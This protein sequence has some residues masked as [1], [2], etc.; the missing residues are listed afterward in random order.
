MWRCK[1]YLAVWIT[2]DLFPWS[3]GN[4]EKAK[5]VPQRRFHP[6]KA[7]GNIYTTSQAGLGTLFLIQQQPSVNHHCRDYIRVAPPGERH[8]NRLYRLCHSIFLVHEHA[9]EGCCGGAQRPTTSP[10]LWLHQTLIKEFMEDLTVLGGRWLLQEPEKLTTWARVSFKQNQDPSGSRK[11]RSPAS[12]AFLSV[13][14]L[15]LHQ[16]WGAC[17][18]Y[19]QCSLRDNAS[20]QETNQTLESWLTSVDKSGLPGKFKA[21]IYQHGIL[22]CILWPLIYEVQLTTVEGFANW[23]SHYLYRWLGLPQPSNIALY[24][25]QSHLRL[26]LRSLNEELMVWHMIY[27]LQNSV[28]SHVC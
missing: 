17:W 23:L 14:P 2:Q 18:R 8:H 28:Y 1:V 15:S 25:H 26:P 11:T 27:K 22:T 4:P 10:E 9:S 12:S 6:P 21:W 13:E 5:K 24:S 16:W 7:G 19:L 3:F 20:I